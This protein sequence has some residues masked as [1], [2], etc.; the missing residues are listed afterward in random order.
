MSDLTE[1]G[2][3]LLGPEKPTAEPEAEAKPQPKK[4]DKPKKQPTP[5]APPIEPTPEPEPAPEP[6]MSVAEYAA[7]ADASAILLAG[8]RASLGPNPKY[9]TLAEWREALARFKA[10]S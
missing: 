7:V 9:R 1:A 10:T 6:T 5:A 2:N 3:D 8:F 4:K